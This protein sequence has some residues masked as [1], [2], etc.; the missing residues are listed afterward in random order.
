MLLFKFA[1][2]KTLVKTYCFLLLA[3]CARLTVGVTCAGAGGGTPSEEKKAEANKT[4]EKR[5]DSPAS[6]ARGVRHF[7]GTQDPSI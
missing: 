5:T 2:M 7:H 1:E 6:S 3:E 4:P